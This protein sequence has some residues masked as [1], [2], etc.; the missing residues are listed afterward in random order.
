MNDNKSMTT[1]AAEMMLDAMRKL[2][3]KEINPQEAQGI[4]VLGKGV[5]D[6]ANAEISFIRTV[7]GMPSNGGMFGKTILYL[8][9][10]CSKEALNE[11]KLR[12]DMKARNG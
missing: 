2:N 7:K 11:Q 12:L 3:N 5:I 4:A 1:I 8:E 10:E 6:A 9:P